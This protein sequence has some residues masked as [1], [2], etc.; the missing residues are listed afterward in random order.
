[1]TC[2][3][4]GQETEQSAVYFVIVREWDMHRKIEATVPFPDMT[5]C[6][7]QR[8]EWQLTP[9]YKSRPPVGYCSPLP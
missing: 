1:M 7:I 2:E 9:F 8:G 6:Y 3:V 4:K 5:I